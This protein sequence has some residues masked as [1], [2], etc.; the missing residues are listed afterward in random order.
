MNR[1]HVIETANEPDM[2]G[3]SSVFST[4]DL[5]LAREV[6]SNYSEDG[7]GSWVYH[8]ADKLTGKAV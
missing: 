6:E 2:T 5:A 8:V 1:Y 3:S 4:N 7:D